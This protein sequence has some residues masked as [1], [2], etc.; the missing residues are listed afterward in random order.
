VT[1]TTHSPAR[2][3]AAARLVLKGLGRP[4]GSFDASR[5]FRGTAELR[6]HNVGTAAVRRLARS[7]DAEHAEWTIADAALFADA[8][9]VDQYLE[10]KSVGIELL[11]R[12]RREFTPRLLMTWKRWLARGDA[13]NWATTDAICGS[14][15][16]P[17]LVAYPALAPRMRDWA[18]HRSLWVRR[19]SAVSLI[20]SLRKGAAL[21]LA[22]HI[23][24][25]LSD[26]EE[27]LIQKAVGWMLRE[28]GKADPARLDRYLRQHGPAIP[29]TT[30]R[31][32]IERFSRMKRLELLRATRT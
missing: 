13:A 17:L 25:A 15:I 26:D 5:Y 2:T 4:V 3:A 32:A 31:Y 11:A 10:A 18:R 22:Y 9:I 12:H 27:D 21:D 14:L 29:R 19:A 28:A 16:G 1:Q 23:A 8:L 20:P 30:V 7:I 6:F 24:S